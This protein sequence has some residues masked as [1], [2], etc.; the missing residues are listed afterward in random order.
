MNQARKH[1]LLE[2]ARRHVRQTN[3]QIRQ[4]LAELDTT[5]ARDAEAH[6]RIKGETAY[7]DKLRSATV[8][9][10]TGKIREQLE[11]LEGSPYFARC[12]VEFGQEPLKAYY[13]AKFPASELE[14]YSWTAPIATVRFEDPGPVTHSLPGGGKRSGELVR[15]DQF[16]ITQSQIR[17]MTT[18]S[19]DCPR[20][21]LHQEHF[22]S[23]KAGFILPEVVAQMERAQDQ[24]IRAASK[25]A[26]VI[27]GPAGSGKTTLALHRIAYLRQSPETAASYPA[28]S[29]IVF[30]QDMKTQDYFMHLLPELGIHDV[31]IVTWA[32]WVREQLKLRKF[33]YRV[34]PGRT[35]AERDRYEEAKL[36]ALRSLPEAMPESTNVRVALEAYYASAMPP[37]LLALLR[38]ELKEGALDRYDL[39]RLLMWE[40][41]RAGQLMRETE[42]YTWLPGAKVR[43][44]IIRE[45]LRYSLV[46]VDEFQNYLPEQLRLLRSVVD[47]AQESMVYVGDMAQ[48]TQYGTV[49]EWSE[50]AEEI[51]ADRLVRL[52]KVYRNT[53][54]ILEYIRDRGYEVEIPVEVA[55]GPAVVECEVPDAMAVTEYVTKLL[56][57]P[58]M[59][60]GVLARDFD[61]LELV[62][63]QLR[64]DAAVHCLTIREAQ[65]VEFDIVC[66]LEPSGSRLRP[67][68]DASPWQRIA[69]D[70]QYV[71]LTRAITELHI[72]YCP[73]AE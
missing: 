2:E 46:M 51:P 12:D 3:E 47:P 66:L 1:Q 71:A 59:T 15:K 41:Q 70:L 9:E 48:Q 67:E 4:R 73:S 33:F 29:I 60:I 45:P 7:E 64:D 18:E 11:R 56:R 6:R 68:P 32:E 16:M 22:A 52:G 34:R 14:I 26:F 8:G 19:G 58:G 69:W 28:D 50:I 63:E 37:D 39:T 61:E 36:K 31:Q 54:Q 44:K 55:E 49:R 17:F 53:R 43:T 38:S 24:V 13:F 30:V 25:G 27:A 65:G 57:R 20:Q 21:L 10:N 23:R 72:V 42:H 40:Q 5:L 35:E 62:A